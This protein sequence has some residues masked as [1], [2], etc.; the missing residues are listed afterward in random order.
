M[1]DPLVPP[2]AA[3]ALG[4]LTARFV[5]F[6]LRDLAPPLAALVTLSLIASWKKAHVAAPASA[7]AATVFAGCLAAVL[8]RPGPPPELNAESGEAVILEGCVVEPSALSVDREHFILELAPRARARVSLYWKDGERPPA[9]AYGRRVELDAKV[10]RPHNFVNPGSFDYSG[11]LARQN[12]YWTAS[13]R[14]ADVRPL[15]GEC[16]NRFWRAIFGLRAAALDRIEQMYAGDAYAIGMM[17]AILIGESGRLE[18]VW[19]EHFRRTG[20]Y[21]ALVISGLHVT[22]LAGFL[23]FLLRLCVLRE[24]HALLITALGAWLYSLVS[25]WQAPV[26][27]SAGGFTLYLIGRYFYRQRRLLNLLAAVAIGFLLLDPEQM[28]D[29]SFQ[30][31]FL[32][33]AAIAIFAAPL[34]DGTSAPLFRGLRGLSEKDRDMHLEPRTA[35]FRVELRLLAE[36][37]SLWTRLPERGALAALGAILRA[38]FYAYDLVIVSATVQV[39]LAL[40]MVVYFHR[41]SISGLSANL[42][43][44]PLMSLVVPVGFVAVFTG[45]SLPARIARLLLIASE[46]AVDWHVGWEPNWR[47]PDPPLWLALALVAALMALGLAMHARRLWRALALSPALAL[48]SL[49]IWHPFAPQIEPGCLELSAI[50]VGQGDSLFVA[51]PGGRLMVVDGG[52][53]PVFGGRARPRLD[54]GEDVVSPYLWTRSI[55]R[56]DVIVSTHGHEDHIGGLTALIDNFHPSELWTGAT[57][58]SPAWHAL[59]ETARRSGVRIVP[60][61]AGLRFTYGGALIEVLSPPAGYEPGPAPRNNDSLVLRISHGD[62]SFLLT[63][64]IERRMEWSIETSHADVLKSP[65]H[66][67]RTSNTE[68]FLDTV[69]PAFV[70]ISAGLGNSYGNPHPEVIRRLEQRHAAILRTDRMGLVTVRTDGRRIEGEVPRDARR[71]RP[72]W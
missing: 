19:T 53:I 69:R 50:D 58:D 48:L 52:G 27:R 54:I 36:T 56:L 31:S 25:G 60:M 6:E 39:G 38:V 14:A 44:V 51:L 4:V 46:K 62:R 42:I 1:R 22:V 2:L 66:G 15:A 49:M 23:L 71:L 17:Q 26:V 7:L 8:H 59:S 32:S 30:L 16:G 41:L 20:T 72:A 28:F 57:P 70:L 12:I 43:V 21:H 18:K 33:V 61:R 9:L 65:H 63:G 47:V 68:L 11:Y 35:A 34:L 5:D 37:V 64:D 40:P 67:S 10:R 45:W 29:A 3:L 13:A 24:E 55:R